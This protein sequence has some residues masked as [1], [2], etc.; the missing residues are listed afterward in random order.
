[1]NATTKKSPVKNALSSDGRLLVR[2]GHIW[3]PVTRTWVLR[4]RT[5]VLRY[6]PGRGARMNTK[7]PV[8][9]IDAINL[10][11]TKTIALLNMLHVFCNLEQR[12]ITRGCVDG[13]LSDAATGLA[14]LMDDLADR[15]ESIKNNANELFELAGGVR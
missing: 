3:S 13:T 2:C 12:D 15:V 14:V 11:T 1:M 10:E 6:G 8:E 7:D 5:W 9:L 4:R